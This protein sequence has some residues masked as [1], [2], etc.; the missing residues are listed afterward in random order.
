VRGDVDVYKAR[1]GRV[2]SVPL[3][4]SRGRFRLREEIWHG[5][6]APPSQRS[7]V[8]NFSTIARKGIRTEGGKDHEE[9]MPPPTSRDA[10]T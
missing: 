6:E 7:S 10:D 2:P 1:V 8:Q 9:L 5:T 3:F 4:F